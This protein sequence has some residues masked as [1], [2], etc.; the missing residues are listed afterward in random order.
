MDER[1]ILIADNFEHLFNELGYKKTT[2]EGVAKNLGMSKKTIYKYFKSKE[3]A[4]KFL[5]DRFAQREVEELRIK[6]SHFENQWK[7]LEAI[8]SL[9]FSRV[10][11]AISKGV[12]DEFSFFFPSK[13]SVIAFQSAYQEMVKEILII[14]INKGI[15][16]VPDLNV[17][18][19]FIESI[20]ANGIDQL[21]NN[22]NIDIEKITYNAVVKILK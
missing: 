11:Q 7:K 4:F 9:C 22:I 17:Y 1:K 8:N 18:I 20:I 3:D 21:K 12:K 6:I 14:G 15:F 16:N 19:V 13:I 10:K 5:V 2:V